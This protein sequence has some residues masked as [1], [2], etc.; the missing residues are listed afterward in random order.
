[1]ASV[2]LHETESLPIVYVVAID[3]QLDFHVAVVLVANGGKLCELPFPTSSEGYEQLVYWNP[4]FG[5]R[6]V[7]GMEGTA[8]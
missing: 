8:S 2:T 6:P 1:M 3:T 5:D 7:F 4:Q